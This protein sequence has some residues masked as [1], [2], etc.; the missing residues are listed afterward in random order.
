MGMVRI[1]LMMI[2]SVLL[3]GCIGIDRPTVEVT[4]VR[5]EDNSQAAGRVV[6]DLKV[7]NPNDEELPIPTVSYTVDVVGAGSFS[8]TDRPHAAAPR[9]G[10]VTM[11]LAAGVRGVSLQGKRY[12]VDGVLVFEPQGE[13]RRVFYDNYVPL[14][15]S[16]FSAEGVLE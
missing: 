6:F 8:F 16:R 13:L 1:V 4:D 15:R 10:E 9:D 11:S 7:I 3:T 14:P 12:E 5:L 2:G